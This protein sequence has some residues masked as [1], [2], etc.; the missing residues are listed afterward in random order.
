MKKTVGDILAKLV[1]V[2]TIPPLMVLALLLIAYGAIEGVYRS[3]QE[4]LISILCLM[5]IPILAYPLA[6]LIPRYK[7]R[8]REGQRNLAFIMSAVGYTGAVLWGWRARIS[9]L[10]M[11]IHLTYFLSVCALLVFNKALRLRASGHACSI[12]GPLI[13]F[14]YM[15]GGL[16]LIPCALLFAA[17]AWASL[18]MKRHTPG[19]LALGS[20]C[21]GMAFCLSFLA[22][23]LP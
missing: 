17:I 9:N 23:G 19:E 22:V 3:P 16:S 15:F 2:A 12:A 8:G 6:E 11:Q 1:R 7:V 10:L 4:L 5:F 14:A 13:F 18:H 20:A 21:A